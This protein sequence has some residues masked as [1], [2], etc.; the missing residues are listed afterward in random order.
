[1]SKYIGIDREIAKAAGLVDPTEKYRRAEERSRA[2]LLLIQADEQIRLQKVRDANLEA[3]VRQQTALGLPLPPPLTG[4]QVTELEAKIGRKLSHAEK[5]LGTL[6]RNDAPN[7]N[8]LFRPVSKPSSEAMYDAEIA[9]AE[10]AVEVE[11]V[12]RLSE[13]QRTLYAMKQAKEDHLRKQLGAAALKAHM[14]KHKEKIG[15]LQKVRQDAAI[16]PQWTN[17][18]LAAVDSA[19]AQLQFGPDGDDEVAEQLQSNVSTIML[20][21]IEQQKE[22]RQAISTAGGLKIRSDSG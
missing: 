21:H 12:S 4:Q 2:E 3:F 6:G 7:L 9:E 8:N 11:R 14:E 20:C 19:L 1:M 18:Q 5:A 22:D 15:W 13:A 16:D 17:E 10:R